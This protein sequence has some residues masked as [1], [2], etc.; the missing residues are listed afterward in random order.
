VTEDCSK[1]HM[2]FAAQDNPH[3]CAEPLCLRGLLDG[4][5]WWESDR[6]RL[7]KLLEGVMESMSRFLCLRG[8]EGCVW[9]VGEG[10]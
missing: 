7:I 6:S 3:R 4:R 5:V 1:L 9:W 8:M 2:M 10:S